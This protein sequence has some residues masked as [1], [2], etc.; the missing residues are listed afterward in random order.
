M[1]GIFSYEDY[2]RKEWIDYNGHMNDSAYA[3]VFSLTLESFIDYMGL[4]AVK[5]EAYAYTIYTLETHLCYLQEAYEK[6]KLLVTLQ[7]LDVDSKRLHVFL[8]MKN[9]KSGVLASSEQMLMGMDTIRRRP[10]QF[11]EPVKDKIEEIW[12]EHKNLPWPERVGS[13]IGIKRNEKGLRL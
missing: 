4:D 1:D 6:E 9:T 10:S 8:E 3:V 13:K 5:R 7:L 12:D 2:V 11:P